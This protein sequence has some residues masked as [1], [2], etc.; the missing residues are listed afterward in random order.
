MTISKRD[1]IRA[2][3]TKK[4]RRQR[5]NTILWVG[6]FIVVLTLLL[7]S[8][9]IYNALKPAGEFVRITPEAHP[10]EDGIAIG[11]PDAPVVIEIYEDFQC[12]ICKEYTLVDEDKFFDSPYIA[13][14]QV[15]Y[16]FRQFPIL[17]DASL[18]TRESYQSANAS[19]CAMEQGRFW[20]YHDILF[21]NQ[22]VAENAGAFS[23]K[24][25]QAFAE[26]LGLDM[27]AFNQCFNDDKYS[28]E[29]EADYQ[30]GRAAGATGTPWFYLNGTLLSP[31]YMTYD[32]LKTAV[33]AAIIAEGNQ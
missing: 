3:R 6:G 17:D 24:R 2:Q 7:A 22:G 26:S 20:D 9:S 16:V 1:A 32:Q 12:P 5:M 33:E 19:M 15:Y 25:L 4:K 31:G 13:D 18:V 11:N 21:A 14:G 10:M 30:K 23:D 28:A 29:I 27:T 8:P